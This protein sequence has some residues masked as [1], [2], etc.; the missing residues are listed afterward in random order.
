MSLAERK[1]TCTVPLRIL[2]RRSAIHKR[3][4]DFLRYKFESGGYASWKR[5]R[6]EEDPEEGDIFMRARL[7]ALDFARQ[8]YLLQYVLTNMSFNELPGR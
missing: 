2:Y 5:C 8:F 3:L 7:I 6:S 1:N 4:E